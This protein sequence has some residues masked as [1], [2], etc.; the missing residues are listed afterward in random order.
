MADVSMEF[1]G[2]RASAG[3]ILSSLIIS[4]LQAG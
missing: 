2:S 4:F 1:N 3:S